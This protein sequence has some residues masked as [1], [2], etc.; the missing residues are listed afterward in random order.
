MRL[1]QTASSPNE[2]S[3]ISA[4]VE[5][6]HSRTTSYLILSRLISTSKPEQGCKMSTGSHRLSIPLNS[7]PCQIHSSL[8]CGYRGLTLQSILPTFLFSAFLTETLILSF[9]YR[10]AENLW[11][12]IYKGG[13]ASFPQQAQGIGVTAGTTTSARSTP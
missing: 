1:V 7:G 2:S 11:I 8:R 3:G 5:T 9:Q 6:L 13:E 12:C 4:I 10:N